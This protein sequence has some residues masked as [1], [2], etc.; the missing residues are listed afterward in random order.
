MP[1]TC[2]VCRSDHLPEIDDALLR[3]ETLRLIAA[4]FDLSSSAVK[5]HKSAHLPVQSAGDRA[6]AARVEAGEPTRL[7]QV[8]H[9]LTEART[10]LTDARAA[11][12]QETALK[13]IDRATKLVELEA[14]LRGE[15]Q[16]GSQIGVAVQVSNGQVHTLEQDAHDFE[17]AAQVL[18]SFLSGSN[19]QLLAPAGGLP[20]PVEEPPVE[21]EVVE[22]E[23]TPDIEICWPHEG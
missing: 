11:G 15:L 1:R 7:E 21:A 13:A 12:R 17:E 9:L 4:R 22:P 18:E 14:K 23:P 8:Q 5:R 19:P 6:E 20:E 3:G 16:T 2:T 10:I